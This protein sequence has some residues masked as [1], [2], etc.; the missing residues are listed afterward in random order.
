MMVDV[1][2]VTR[3]LL[4]G[5]IVIFVSAALWPGKGGKS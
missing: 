3:L 4:V 2:G 5:L 1:E